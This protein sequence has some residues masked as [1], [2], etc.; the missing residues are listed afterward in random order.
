MFVEKA[1]FSSSVGAY[2]DRPSVPDCALACGVSGLGY[3]P[4]LPFIPGWRD[5]M[6]TL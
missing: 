4:E 5:F 1:S 2:L 3:Q 6:E